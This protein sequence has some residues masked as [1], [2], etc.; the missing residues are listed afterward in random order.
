MIKFLLE[1]PRL[2]E[3][4]YYCTDTGNRS[5]GASGKSKFAPLQRK[6]CTTFIFRFF[7]LGSL[8]IDLTL[9]NGIQTYFCCGGIRSE[10][11][12]LKSLPI[13]HSIGQ[14]TVL[15]SVMPTERDRSFN[16]FFIYTS[17]PGFMDIGLD[18]F[19]DL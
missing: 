7:H 19:V 2:S 1:T 4:A 12:L 10:K 9:T 5:F 13:G 6:C 16:F 11:T 3:W 14:Y 8:M 15:I 17:L 18:I